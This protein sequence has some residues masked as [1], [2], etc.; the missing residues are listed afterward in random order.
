MEVGESMGLDSSSRTLR[1]TLELT[2]R[3]GKRP[4]KI[5]VDSRSTSNYMLAQECTAKKILVEK[6]IDGDEE[7]WIANES[8][9]K[10]EGRIKI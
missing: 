1:R 2:S 4:L 6:E 7:L 10:T 5:L 9:I 8:F 3:F